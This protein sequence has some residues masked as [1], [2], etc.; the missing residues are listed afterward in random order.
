GINYL[1]PDKPN[2]FIC[3]PRSSYLIY[4]GSCE[5]WIDFVEWL[6]LRGARK[7]IVSSES[8]VQQPYPSRRLDLIRSLYGAKIHHVSGRIQTKENASEFISEVYKI[9]PINTVF[10]LPVK[11][12]HQLKQSDIK[13]V[14]YLDMALRNI[15]PKT[16]FVNLFG[17]AFGVSQNRV[18]VEFP[19]YNIEW[20][21][22]VDFTDV[23]FGLDEILALRT[24]FVIIKSAKVSDILQET[25]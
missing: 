9:G 20:P 21:D 15:S 14:Q 5:M 3:D 11:T 16:T 19:T 2:K 8:K 4:G 22:T 13:P 7:I 25:T 6:V 23:L 24:R 18:D 10:I 17:A 12:Q 1:N